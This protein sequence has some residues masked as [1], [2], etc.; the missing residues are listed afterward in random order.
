KYSR[1]WQIN[2][3]GKETLI[4][5]CYNNERINFNVSPNPFDSELLIEF[6]Q[7]KLPIN[8]TLSDACGR[9]IYTLLSHDIK[10]TLN[11]SQLVAGIYL[12]NISGKGF[13]E[14]V[15]VIKIE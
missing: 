12:L 2:F 5:E 9:P 3:D 6:E 10:T 4:G 1:V 8:I 15:K 13:T 7:D 11:T 14:T